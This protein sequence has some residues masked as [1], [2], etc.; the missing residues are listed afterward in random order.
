MLDTARLLRPTGAALAALLL[1]AVA[2]R[3]D[4]AQS[5][6]AQSPTALSPDTQRRIDAAAA[7]VLAKTGAASAS[8]AIVKDGRIAYLRA[9]GDA[10][11]EPK[12]PAQPGTRYAIGS[13]SKQFTAA[14]LLLLEQ[15]GRLSLDDRVERWVP[16]LT[17]GRDITIRQLLS[18]TAGYQDYWPQDYMF[19]RMREPASPEFVMDTWARKPLDYEPGTRWQYSNTGYIVAARIVEQASGEPFFSFLHKR[20]FVPLGMGTV[21]DFDREPH[22]AGMAE[23]YTQYA[24]GPSRVAAAS[25]PGWLF[26]AGQLAMTAEDLA[27]WDVSLMRREL[28]SRA[29]YLALETDT[30]LA[31]GAGTQYGLGTDVEIENHRRK[32]AHGGAVNGFTS[33]NLVYPDDGAAIVVLVNQDASPA[34]SQL[35][36]KLVEILF[37]DVQP[38]DAAATARARAIFEGLQ[39]GRLD[40][41]QFTA[42]ANHY[43]STQAIADFQASLAPLGAPTGFRQARRWLRGGMTGRSY[44]A[45][46]ADRTLRVWTYETPDGQLEQFQVAVKE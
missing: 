22:A 3:A 28:L 23:G 5:P 45:K 16:G 32:L 26:G 25:A 42:N 6:T 43:F 18:H 1:C 34:P 29:S 27:R 8:V 21:L 13:I 33:D 20:I 46:F 11:L 39:Q 41:G 30:R 44:E 37:E 14:A 12:L 31:S 9:Y 2:A 17:R 7:E 19:P 4:T 38:A 15:D 40:R 24:L 35:S 10:A 36:G